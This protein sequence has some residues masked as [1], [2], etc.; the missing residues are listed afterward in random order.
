MELILPT[1][2]NALEPTVLET[3]VLVVIG[4]SR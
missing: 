3:K 2:L 4:A 1:R